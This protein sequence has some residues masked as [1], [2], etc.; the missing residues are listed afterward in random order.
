MTTSEGPSHQQD[1]LSEMMAD[2]LYYQKQL[3]VL[4]KNRHEHKSDDIN[5]PTTTREVCWCCE[6]E[7]IHHNMTSRGNYRPH[8]PPLC[9]PYKGS[10]DQPYA[11]IKQNWVSWCQLTPRD[12]IEGHVI[13]TWGCRFI[14]NAVPVEMCWVKTVVVAHLINC[15]SGGGPKQHTARRNSSYSFLAFWPTFSSI[16]SE[17]CWQSLQNHQPVCI[18]KMEHCQTHIC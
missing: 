13:L 15:H 6:Q 4:G 8:S 10:A 9:G 12:Y 7:Q 3:C 5:C 2:W 1:L 11:A 17:I 16:L 14:C 18:A